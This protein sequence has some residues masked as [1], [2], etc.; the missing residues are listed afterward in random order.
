MTLME[1]FQQGGFAMYWILLLGLAA[2][3]M[4]I[5][6]AAMARKWSLIVSAILLALIGGMAVFGTMTSLHKVDNALTGLDLEPAL[7]AQ[8]KAQGHKEAMRPVQFGGIVVALGGALLIVGEVRRR[9]KPA[10]H[11]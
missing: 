7:M 3:P 5:V 6:H 11:R 9:K 8:M 2:I 10:S 1:V 4:G